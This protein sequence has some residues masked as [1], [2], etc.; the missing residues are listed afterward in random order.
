MIVREFPMRHNI[1]E[2]GGPALLM[3]VERKTFLNKRKALK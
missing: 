1:G 2:R 3:I